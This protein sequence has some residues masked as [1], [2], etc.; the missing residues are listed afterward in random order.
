MSYGRTY[1]LERDS[2]VAAVPVG[3]ADGLHR[4]LSNRMSMLVRG[5]GGPADR[6]HLHGYV[7][8]GRDGCAR[9]ADGRCGHGVR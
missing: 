4:S 7:Y 2:L 6:P 1:T 9:C 3:Y 5:K 8:A